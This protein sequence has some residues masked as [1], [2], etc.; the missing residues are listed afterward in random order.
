MTLVDSNI[1]LDLFTEDPHWKT[2]SAAALSDAADR[3]DVAINPIV[4]AELAA[5]FRTLAELEERL[6]DDFIR[7]PLP[8]EAGFLAGHAFLEYRRRG[9]TRNSPLPDFYIGAHA[10]VSNLQLLTRDT[11]RY[12]GY[13]PTVRMIAP[14]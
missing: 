6:G 14:T 13:F 10:A 7:L 4:V 5:R 8:Y 12:K 1:I 3:G 9:G 2:W 11:A